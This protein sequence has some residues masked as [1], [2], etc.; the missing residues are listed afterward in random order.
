[1]SS[2]IRLRSAAL[3]RMEQSLANSDEPLLREALDALRR[4][5][6]RLQRHKGELTQRLQ[7]LV[8]GIEEPP[9]SHRLPIP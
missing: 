3:V 1:M 2:E 7:V 8:S 9:T 6:S 4:E 5:L